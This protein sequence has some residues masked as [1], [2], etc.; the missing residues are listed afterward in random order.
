[1][2]VRGGDSMQV[3]PSERFM[4]YLITSQ[5]LLAASHL[6]RWKAA[7][8]C[9]LQRIMFRRLALTYRVLNLLR[10]D[11]RLPRAIR[12]FDTYAAIWREQ[13]GKEPR[14]EL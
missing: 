6:P 10:R 12:M 4:R 5:A 1:M 7:I 14:Y 8:Y 11:A 2:H 13:K 9:L 3:D